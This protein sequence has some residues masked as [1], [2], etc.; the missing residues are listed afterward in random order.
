M[1]ASLTVEGS[2][3]PAPAG[4]QHPGRAAAHGADHAAGVRAAVPRG[5]VDP[6]ACSARATRTRR[7]RC[8]AGSR[9]GALLRVVMETYFAVLR[10][11]SRTVRTRLA[12]GPVVRPGARP[13]AAA[14]APHGADRRGRRRDLRL[15]V[16]VAIAAPKLYRTLRAAPAAAVPEAAAPDGDLADL[17]AREVAGRRTHDAHGAG[18][19]GRWTA[20]PWR[21]ASTSTSTTWNAVPTSARAPAHRPPAPPWH[22]P[23]TGRP[24]RQNRGAGAAGGGA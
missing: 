18:R 21:W 13:D 22:P 23:T 5:A 9:C 15:A 3:D 10:A 17:G 8:C 4:R 1:G 11:Q 14:A 7:R 6:A 20:T 2:H 24:G 12:A 19:P 16:I